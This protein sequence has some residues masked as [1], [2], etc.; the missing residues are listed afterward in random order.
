M[1]LVKGSNGLIGPFSVT[2]DL[3][4]K[5]VIINVKKNTA[6]SNKEIIKMRLR[7]EDLEMDENAFNFFVEMSVS[8]GLRYCIVLI[9]LLKAHASSI[10]IEDVKEMSKLFH[11][12]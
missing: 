8:R 5:V 7:E 10:K 3:I 6:D 1:A 9:P 11:D 2:K 4:D 12:C